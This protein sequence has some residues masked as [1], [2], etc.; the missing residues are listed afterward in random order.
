[1]ELSVIIV[2]WNVRELLARCLTSLAETKQDI[3]F[4]IIVVDNASADQSAAMVRERFSH[5]TVIE[6]QDNL[7]FGKAN[8][9]G[10]QQA[11][12][13]FVL[14]LNDD[15][16]VFDHTLDACV[17]Y[18][19]T[20]ETVGV[21][22]CSIKNP[23]GSQQPSV[24]SAPTLYSQLVVLSKVY[25]FFPQLLRQYRMLGF[26]YTTTQPVDEVMG[27][28]FMMPRQ[29]FDELGGFDEHFFVWFEETDLATRVRAAGKSVVYFADAHII[30]ARG[31]SFAQHKTVAKQ[32]MFNTSMVYYF[33]KHAS[34]G[35]FVIIWLLSWIGL[36]LAAVLALVR[37][38][39]HVPAS[40]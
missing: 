34:Y 9:I 1:M 6:N 38:I 5:V 24:R 23:D 29:L 35:A 40:R 20:H 22:G 37:R 13:K 30:H 8:N 15:T 26:D 10:V 17:A 28:F 36:L 19:Q 7:G 27:A 31:A 14:F 2:S 12:G 33:K 39:I 32:R 11:S 25:N 18:M 16:E 4:E 3:Q 21:L